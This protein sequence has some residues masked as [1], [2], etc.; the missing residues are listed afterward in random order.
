MSRR[1]TNARIFFATIYTL[2]TLEYIIISR[3]IGKNGQNKI[4]FIIISIQRDT[5]QIRTKIGSWYRKIS[6]CIEIP[7]LIILV[8]HF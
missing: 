8:I 4:F 6:K 7:V 3:A 2:T 5:K 1:K